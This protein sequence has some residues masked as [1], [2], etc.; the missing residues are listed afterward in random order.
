MLKK[1]Q[2]EYKKIASEALSAKT[3]VEE[4]LRKEEHRYALLQMDKTNFIE[5][6]KLKQNENDERVSEML[7]KLKETY[8]RRWSSIYLVR[9][10]RHWR[11]GVRE[12][13]YK[14][15][16]SRLCENIVSGYQIL[17]TKRMFV[18]WSRCV[19]QQIH[20]RHIL[21]A[22]MIR[23]SLRALFFAFHRWNR[24]ISAVRQADFL[25]KS[26]AATA[27]ALLRK[28]EYSA[29]QHTF[30]L[31]CT[32]VRRMVLIRR[33]LRKI[34]VPSMRRLLKFGM[35]RWTWFQERIKVLEA[36]CRRN[37]FLSNVMFE[38][39]INLNLRRHLHAWHKQTVYAVRIRQVLFTHRLLCARQKNFL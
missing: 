29:L 8:A 19:K 33:K 39:L 31:W 26:R 38:K 36:E 22:M 3:S 20:S 17:K 16:R 9:A 27:L 30:S 2:E 28:S 13:K 10:I 4:A 14:R 23:T 21:K 11:E 25:M 18:K 1:E 6:S 5:L 15:E 12:K 34:L 7:E 37:N 32:S 35:S 24:E